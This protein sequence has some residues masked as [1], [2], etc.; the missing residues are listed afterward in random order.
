[1]RLGSSRPSAAGQY[2]QGQQ[3]HQGD[4]TRRAHGMNR[5]DHATQ[6]VRSSAGAQALVQVALQAAAVGSMGVGVDDIHGEL[7]EMAWVEG[8][9][10]A[11]SG[12]AAFSGS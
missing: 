1:M 9:A 2:H 6:P 10:V 4:E 8:A 12:C 11:A 5:L 3:Q 7:G